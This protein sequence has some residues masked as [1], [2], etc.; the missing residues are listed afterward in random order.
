MV[1]Q[2]PSSYNILIGRP[3][4]SAFEAVVSTVHGMMRFP[5]AKGVTTIEADRREGQVCS[6]EE[7][8]QSRISI[9]SKYPEQS[10]HVGTTLSPKGMLF[11][12]KKSFGGTRMSSLGVMRT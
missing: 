11:Q 3:R 9:N 1:V 2:S 5:S 12:E 10:I 8:P 7:G 6:I 4:I